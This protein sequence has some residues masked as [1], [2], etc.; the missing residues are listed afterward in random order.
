METRAKI[1]DRGDYLDG[2]Q[3]QDSNH[4]EG[5]SGAGNLKRYTKVPQLSSTFMLTGLPD[6]FVINVPETVNL[7]RYMFP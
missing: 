7:L 3:M 4:K 1:S 5:D 2:V 6:R